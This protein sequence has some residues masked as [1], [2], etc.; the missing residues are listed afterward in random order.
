MS[1]FI[2]TL[3]QQIIDSTIEA[4]A[5]REDWLKALDQAFGHDDLDPLQKGH[6]TENHR[7]AWEI[8]QDA[9]SP[10]E[11]AVRVWRDVFRRGFLQPNDDEACVFTVADETGR[12]TTIDLSD[13]RYAHLF[14]D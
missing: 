6:G 9:T 10:A 8:D 12:R 3:A 1:A 5:T 11:A 7:L 14:N 4:E 13:D 2:N